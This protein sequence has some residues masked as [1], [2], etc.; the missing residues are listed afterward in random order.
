MSDTK[1]A[2]LLH[3]AWSRGDQW[4]PARAAFEDRG[5]TVHTPTLRHHEL[6]LHKGAMKIAPLSLRDYTD[7]LVALVDSLD[8]PPLLVA[9]S[10]GGRLAQMVAVRSDH[11]GVVAACPAGVGIA[12]INATALRI[13]LGH[14]RQRRP[15]A[16]PVYPM[17][18]EVFRHGI[19]AAQTEE[20]AREVFAELV[21]ESTRAVYW[22]LAHPRLD[23]AKAARID[24]AAVTGP[25]LVI[26]G[27]C[28]R[29]VPPRSRAR[30]Q[31][32]IGTQAM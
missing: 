23:R 31:L 10:L 5:Y 24:F 12:G 27:E 17:T 14:I 22:E 6:P 26:G 30:P 8:T 32:G 7:D 18:W 1:H 28:D 16:K 25:V 4:V 21:C 20:L 29:I 15:W 2:V 13:S 11:D 3:G 9:H 19:A